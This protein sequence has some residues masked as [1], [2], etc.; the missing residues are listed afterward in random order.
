VTDNT[1][2]NG[3]NGLH[4]VDNVGEK[5]FIVLTF[6]E[7]VIVDKALLDSVI[8]DSDISVWVGSIADAFDTPI[9]LSDSLLADL[10]H[11]ETDNTSSSHTRWADINNGEVAGNVVIIAASV[12]DHTPEDRFKLNEVK[13]QRLTQPTI[14]VYGNT[15]VATAMGVSDA[16]AS[17]YTNPAVTPPPV[18]DGGE[19]LTPGY[20]RQPH[21]FDAWTTYSPQDSFEQTFGVNASGSPT[22]LDAVSAGGGGEFALQRHAVAALLNA[23]N[24]G[25]DYAYSE[26]QV[27][28]IVQQAYATG[29][30]ES[31]KN[32]FEAQNELGGDAADGDYAASAQTTSSYNFDGN[33]HLVVENDRSFNQNYATIAFSFSTENARKTQGLISK[34]ARGYGD[35]GHLTILVKKGKVE[36]RLQSENRT[37]K[38][39]SGPIESNRMYDVAFTYGRNGM[40]LYL[41]GERVVV[42][43]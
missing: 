8:N 30:F 14:G 39:K 27:I 16:D 33:D 41:D 22:L 34:D 18:N 11:Y 40:N 3:G 2:G 12:E 28:Q 20:W 25:I 32:L 26:A 19:G 29:Q 38:I 21:H 36:V 31:A 6:S 35:G 9:N 43:L 24:S 13:V 1:E 23:A 7:N 10:D 17:H 15:A 37:Y 42:P 5:N 4:R